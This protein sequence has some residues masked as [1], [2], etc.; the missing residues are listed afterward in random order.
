MYMLNKF[1]IFVIFISILCSS[2]S[3]NLKVRKIDNEDYYLFKSETRLLDKKDGS[4]LKKFL[5]YSFNEIDANYKSLK[6]CNNFLSKN[7][8]INAKC[9]VF[10]YKLTNYGE[11]IFED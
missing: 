1:T 5:G 10:N 11:S 4:I 8:S 7:L 9:K 3:S 2:C 6:F